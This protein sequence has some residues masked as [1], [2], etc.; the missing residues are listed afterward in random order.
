MNA[1]RIARWSSPRVLAPEWIEGEG[2]RVDKMPTLYGAL[3]YSL[4]R[5]DSRTLRLSIGGGIA[6]KLVLRPPLGAPL[7][8]ATVDGNP[9]AGMEGD[10]VTVLQTPAEIVFTT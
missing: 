7:I 4:R 5:V 1:S 10:A 8:R 3:S 6:A 9:P 2:V